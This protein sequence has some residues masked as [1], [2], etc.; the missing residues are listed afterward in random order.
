[1]VSDSVDTDGAGPADRP[2]TLKSQFSCQSPPPHR[3]GSANGGNGRPPVNAGG[4][5]PPRGVARPD[6]GRQ[7][8]DD[9]QPFARPNRPRP[10]P[11]QVLSAGR[12]IDSAGTSVFTAFDPA[13]GEPTGPEFPVSRW[14]ELA[15][16]ADA[17]AAAFAVAAPLGPA[18]VADFLDD[19]ADRL[20]ADADALAEVAARET[21]LPRDGRLKNGELPRT[22]GQ[23]RQAAAAARDG[24]WRRPTVSDGN[25]RSILEPLGPAVVIGPNNFPFAFNGISGGDFAAAVA[26]GCPVIAKA[27]PNHPATS[28]RLA[29][30]A[31]A[32][33]RASALPDAWVQLFYDCDHTDGAK[34][35]A[36]RRVAAVA[37]TGSK[38]GGLALKNACD[39]AGTPAFFELGSVNPVFVLPGAF[40]EREEAIAEDLAG[41]ALLGVGQFCTQPG[42]VVVPEGG[43]GE[44]L[45]ADLA[46]RFETAPTPPLLAA[47]VVD[48][49]K[50][51]VK[52]LTDAGAELLCG[53]EAPDEP[54]FR[55]RN[56]LLRVDGERFLA[57]PG[58]FQTECFGPCTL[59]VTTADAARRVAVAESL[60]G[61]LTACVVSATNVD[62]DEEYGPLSHALRT[63]C[64]RLLNDKMP[65][66]VAVVP[67]MN[68]GGP[69]PASG[70]P[71]FTAVGVP[72]SLTRFTRLACYDG[73]R[74]DR[75]PAALRDAS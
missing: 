55:Y 17:A 5:P 29:E 65:T 67:A 49:L 44:T 41:S 18:A 57:D 68:H 7:D 11:A 25:V 43:A 39:E 42:I 23:L 30:A 53:G 52:T 9:P 21:G 26:A 14:D 15:A 20:D 36:D 56:T 10:V 51:G 16:M 38:R 22:T 64:G 35:V 28:K 69:F 3:G 33:V 58:T 45:A 73:V 13:T 60:E 47:N 66:G 4:H 46:K 34:L 2:H 40:V 70:Q 27:H 32:A 72:A 19:Y 50:A 63:R 74:Q 37:F 59:L 61:Q 54:G 24:S 1:M 6:A 12:W 62:D 48:G 75:L 8:A 31:H 71:H